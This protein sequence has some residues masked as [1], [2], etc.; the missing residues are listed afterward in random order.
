MNNNS[1]IL[2]EQVKDLPQVALLRLFP[3]EWLGQG[4]G[5]KLDKSWED[6]QMDE[7]VYVPEYGY[8]WKEL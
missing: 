4:W 3:T 2:Y 5:Y 7:V 8:E 6:M 1:A